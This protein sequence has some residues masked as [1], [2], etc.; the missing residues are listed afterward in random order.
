[1]LRSRT[2][3]D[4]VLCF[5]GIDNLSL[6]REYAAREIFDVK[7]SAKT[8][9]YNIETAKNYFEGEKELIKYLRKEVKTDDTVL[10]LGAGDIYERILRVVN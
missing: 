8:L 5:K 4:F 6:F 9:F 2:D 10:I 7:G 3:G 1:M